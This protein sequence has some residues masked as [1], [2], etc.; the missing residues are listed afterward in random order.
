MEPREKLSSLAFNALGD[1]IAVGCAKLG[2]LLVWEWRSETYVLKQQVR[3]CGGGPGGCI[4][5]VRCSTLPWTAGGPDSF[6]AALHASWGST[7]GSARTRRPSVGPAFEQRHSSRSC[8]HLALSRLPPN[9]P[10]LVCWCRATTTT[11][12]A[13]P[14]PQTAHTWCR[15]PMMQRWDTPGG[16]VW[17]HRRRV[18]G[19]GRGRGAWG[20]REMGAGRQGGSTCMHACTP[21][22]ARSSPNAA[23]LTTYRLALCLLPAPSRLQVKVWTLSNGFCFVTFADHTAPVTAV[24][25]L[26]RC[27]GRGWRCSAAAS[28]RGSGG[29][30]GR[31][32]RPRLVCP[33][34]ARWQPHRRLRPPLPS[35]HPSLPLRPRSG[36]AVLSASLDGTVRAFDLVRYRNFRTLTTPSPVQ[37]ISLAADPGGEVRHPGGHRGRRKGGE[38]PERAGRGERR[39]RQS[40]RRGH[41]AAGARW[42]AAA[43][44]RG[45]HRLPHRR[46][47]RPPPHCSRQIVCAGS[48]DSFQIFVWSLKTGRLLD[49]LAAHE[50]PVVALS[51][52]P[53][54]SLLAS[55]SWDRCGAPAWR[56]G[57]VALLAACPMRRSQPLPRAWAVRPP[58]SISPGLGACFTTH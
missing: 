37:F 38:G 34:L 46:R 4:A 42:Q 47:R 7:A 5:A 24:Q 52:C 21:S 44:P 43:A 1:W 26:G 17:A 8:S 6:S 40:A 22:H 32:A 14:S 30:C 56:L 57:G 16:A 29:V 39:T 31:P 45:S 50:G 10:R 11:W 54:A 3:W 51:F 9:H 25:F 36:H 27:A 33:R 35:L 23:S 20:Q 58:P 13:P 12:P 55:A 2:Q 48:K 49:V 19:L 18:G 15:G 53:G 41:A 28:L